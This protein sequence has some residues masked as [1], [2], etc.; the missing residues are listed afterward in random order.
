MDK[1]DSDKK[2]LL[3]ELDN[4]KVFSDEIVNELDTHYQKQ[5]LHYMKESWQRFS[6]IKRFYKKERDETNSQDCEN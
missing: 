1:M 6:W 2:E 4:C 5:R 3:R